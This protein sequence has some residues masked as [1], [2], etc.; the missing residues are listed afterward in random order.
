M[1]IKDVCYPENVCFK[2]N[3]TTWDSQ[4]EENVCREYESMAQSHHID[5]S[6]SKSVLVIH[7]SYPFM[8]ASPD[9]TINCE[10]CAHGVLEI[11]CPYSCRDTSL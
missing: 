1:L 2:S 7:E 4:H 8:S 5:F 3:A 9:G 11:K 10:C 6:I